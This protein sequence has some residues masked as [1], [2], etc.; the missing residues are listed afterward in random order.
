MALL[1]IDPR[2]YVNT[3][4][5]GKTLAVPVYG[6][7]EGTWYV[8]ETVPYDYPSYH[9]DRDVTF[10][11][12]EFD[13][14]EMNYEDVYVSGGIDAVI[15]SIL[16]DGS[17]LELTVWYPSVDSTL[18]ERSFLSGVINDGSFVG[19]YDTTNPA[20]GYS[21]FMGRLEMD[22]V[23]PAEQPQPTII[24][25]DPNPVVGFSQPQPLVL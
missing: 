12:H 11:I 7:W 15:A 17:N 25:V 8:D 18:I 10:I 1:Y 13:P 24:D 19:D 20:P 14:I 16:L 5:T 23:E 4:A 22:L 21:G 2:C 9:Q 6:T 3:A